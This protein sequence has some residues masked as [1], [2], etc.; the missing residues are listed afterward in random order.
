M[1]WTSQRIVSVIYSVTIEAETEKEAQEKYA[2]KEWENEKE[3]YR[4]TVDMYWE[5]LRLV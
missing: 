3:V 1:K 2:A 5:Q 4:E